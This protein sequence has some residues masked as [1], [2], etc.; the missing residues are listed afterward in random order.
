MITVATGQSAV[1]PACKQ[2]W[3]E[4]PGTVRPTRAPRTRGDSFATRTRSAPGKPSSAGRLPNAGDRRL[5]SKA[6]RRMWRIG[7]VGMV[8]MSGLLVAACGG[9]S[10]GSALTTST[11]RGTGALDPCLVGTWIDRG[12]SD[13]LTYK[14]TPLVMDGLGGETV[15]ISPGGA[16]TVSFARAVPLHGSVG[17]STYTVAESGTITDHVRSSAGILTFSNVSYTGF[18]ETATLGGATASSPEP[19]PPTPDHYTCSA[20]TMSLSGAGLHAA[21]SR[22]SSSPAPSAASS[23]PDLFVS[24]A[25]I[26]PP[27]ELFAWPKFPTKIQE[28][29]NDWISG[30]IW[31]ARPQSAS[32][33][34]TFSTD[35]SCSGPAA[36]CPPVTEGTVEFSATLPE[37]CTVTFADPSTGAQQSE[38]AD[39]YGH[40][41]YTEVSGPHPGQ[42]VTMPSPCSGRSQLPG[43]CR[44]SA[45]SAEPF[46]LAGGGAAGSQGGAIGLTNHGP[47]TCTLFGYPGMQL[48]GTD[49]HPLPGEPLPT[50][51]IR[52]QYQVV[53]VVPEQSVTLGPG[54]QARFYYMY[55]DTLG[56][57]SPAVCPTASAIDITPPGA[58][59]ELTV[60]TDIA[61]CEG[62]I[63]VSPVTTLM[64]YPL[65][66]GSP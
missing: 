61:P 37:T 50:T 62:H 6:P 28:D 51:V 23:I 35:L 1:D 10:P 60:V 14:G 49:G 42:T 63:W 56:G 5:Q 57:G 3:M 65:V 16:E 32:G 43:R 41:Q 9:R 2:S 40:L 17:T 20:T 8:A 52:G 19:P 53:D 13:T 4:R 21:F 46:A 33:S 18:S 36:S 27:G 58:Y 22:S 45:L 64:P 47:V 11:A 38:R 26:P 44:T 34:G 55:S 24:T 39:V 59:H 29:D 48:F 31:S 25:A 15:T 12:E 7:G 30:I 66:K 54:A